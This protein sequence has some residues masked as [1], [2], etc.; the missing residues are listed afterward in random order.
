MPLIYGLHE[1]MNVVTG[2]PRAHEP[3]AVLLRAGAPVEG[4]ARMLARR[5]RALRPD[6]VASGP[7]KLAKAMGVT[8]A[9]YGAD[10]CAPGAP[11]RVEAGRRAAEAAVTPRINV[12]GGEDLPLRFLVPGDPH[13]SHRSRTFGEDRARLA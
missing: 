2:P 9:L 11:L 6:E 1:C 5:G 10:L 7:G 8:R 12:V 3:Q 4:V 13:V